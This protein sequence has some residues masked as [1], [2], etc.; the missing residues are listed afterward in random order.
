MGFGFVFKHP[1][2][3][4]KAI[5]WHGRVKFVCGCD[6]EHNGRFYEGQARKGMKEESCWDCRRDDTL[7]MLRYVRWMK[8]L[9]ESSLRRLLHKIQLHGTNSISD[10]REC[11]EDLEEWLY[12]YINK[13]QDILRLTPLPLEYAYE[14]IY[15]ADDDGQDY[16]GRLPD[17]PYSGFEGPF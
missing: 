9:S 1:A 16:H 4:I 5:E 13:D 8:G 12:F 6:K 10:R 14:T 2:E 15:R 7:Q 3:C 17:G 11:T